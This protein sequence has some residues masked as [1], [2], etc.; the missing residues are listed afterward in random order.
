MPDGVFQ[1]KM[2][3]VKNVSILHA[4]YQVRLLT[5]RALQEKMTLTITVPKKCIIAQELEDL[6]NLVSTRVLRI[7]RVE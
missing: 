1:S 3:L 2:V 6:I 7:D 4:T 5:F